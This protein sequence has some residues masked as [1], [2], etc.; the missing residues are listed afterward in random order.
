MKWKR[1]GFRY[2][3]THASLRTLRLASCLFYIWL[4]I[5]G[6]PH[7]L[8]ALATI[9]TLLALACMW[10]PIAACIRQVRQGP[11]CRKALRSINCPGAVVVPHLPEGLLRAPQHRVHCS[12][13][14]AVHHHG[15]V[16]PLQLVGSTRQ[17]LVGLQQIRVGLLGGP[18]HC[19]PVAPDG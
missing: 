8:L 17:L 18:G 12:L 16:G 7:A 1:F 13:P 4:G 11:C 9:Q 19:R 6:H 14:G 5:S 15:S 3:V 2:F 10:G